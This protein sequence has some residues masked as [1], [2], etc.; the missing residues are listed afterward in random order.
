MNIFIK[1]FLVTFIYFICTFVIFASESSSDEI[2]IKAT[3]IEKFTHFVEWPDQNKPEEKTFVISIIGKHPINEVIDKFFSDVKIKNRPVKIRKFTKID[4][5]VL[6]S[7]I[8]F[9]AK[10]NKNE[11]K[12]LLDSTGNK[13]I[14]T[15]SDNEDYCKEGVI[16]NFINTDNKIGFEINKK[17]AQN[18]GLAINFLL[19][20]IAKVI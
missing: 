17:A 9:I 5:E 11:L 12:E 14:L 20:N 4:A 16:I 7:D 6:Q 1:F 18:A 15:I 19:F 2:L 8:I 13:P 10:Q 3:F